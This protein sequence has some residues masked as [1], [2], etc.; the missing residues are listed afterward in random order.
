M[1]KEFVHK[2]EAETNKFPI[3]W[4]ETSKKITREQTK[5]LA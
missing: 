2:V 1:H 5:R 3:N 4:K